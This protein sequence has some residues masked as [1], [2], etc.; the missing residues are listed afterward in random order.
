MSSVADLT[1][2][3]AVRGLALS[4]EEHAEGIVLADSGAVELARFAPLDVAAIVEEEDV[5]LRS[6]LGE[7]E[8]SCSCAAEGFCRHLV[9]TATVAFR[10]LPKG[11]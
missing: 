2:A 4:P 1:D 11:Y 6:R 10:R 8:W 7:L 5:E 9:A 3:Q